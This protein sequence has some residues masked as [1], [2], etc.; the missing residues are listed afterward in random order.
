MQ[1]DETR[2]VNITDYS[3]PQGWNKDVKAD[4]RAKLYCQQLEEGQILFFD[5]IPFNL[6]KEHQEFLLSQRQTDSRLHK[7]ISYRPNSNVLRGASSGAQRDRMRDVI[8]NYSK[9]VTAFLA[10]FLLPYAN[11]WS[12][13]Y[14]SFRPLEEEGRDLPFHKRNDLLHVDAFPTRPTQGARILRV[15]TNINPDT[16]RVWNIGE[17][18]DELAENFAEDAG[19]KR[20]AARD[21]SALQ[22]VLNKT[23][24]TMSSVGLPVVDRSAYDK[25]MLRFHD[26]MK[27]NSAYQANCD[28][29]RLE[30]PPQSTW[31]VYTD[32]VPHAALSGQ[33]AL[34]QTYII[35]I[36]ALQAENKAPIRILEKLCKRKLA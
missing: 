12:M 25:F 8:Q 7:N 5:N 32:G 18:F 16:S 3:Y 6:P 20:I 15:F 31:L 22:S 26:Y 10:N 34:E 24:R 27:E 17:R 21:S 14:A 19:L 23:I 13:D 35:P 36:D 30:F 2:W 28:K 4:E 9:E 1:K 29:T 33:F 11:R